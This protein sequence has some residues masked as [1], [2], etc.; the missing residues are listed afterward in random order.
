VGVVVR[1]S[2]DGDGP[3]GLS[4]VVL[5]NTVRPYNL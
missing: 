1:V 4:P 3:G 5:E 2:V